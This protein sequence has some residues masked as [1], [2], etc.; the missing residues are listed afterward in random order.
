M[1]SALPRDRGLGRRR[2]PRPLGAAST[3]RA[4]RRFAP[5]PRRSSRPAASW[6]SPSKSRRRARRW[7]A[8]GSCAPCRRRRAARGRRR[9]PP[10]RRRAAAL[11]ARV[12]VPGHHAAAARRAPPRRRRSPRWPAWTAPISSSSTW[13]SRRRSP[14]PSST[15]RRTAPSDD[16]RVRFFCYEDEVA[17]EVVDGGDGHGGDAHLRAARRRDQRAGHPLHARAGRRRALHVRSAGHAGTLGQAALLR[18]TSDATVAGRLAVA[19]RQSER[20]KEL[21]LILA[22]CST[23]PLPSGT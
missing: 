10:A 8:P 15:V 20:L 19:G 5:P 18:A 6:S 13:P 14:T 11:G 22:A 12:H 4:S 9:R 3:T 1:R 16:V 2:R 7:P 23:E 21:G 17:V